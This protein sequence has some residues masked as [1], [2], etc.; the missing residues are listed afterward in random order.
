[1]GRKVKRKLVKG[2]DA[3]AMGAV[4]AGCRNYFGYPITPQN[5]IPEY[6]AAHLPRAGGQY[7]QAESEV[8]AINML[9]GAAATGVRSMT[10]SSSPG[11]SLMQ[12]GI[13]YMAASELPG[14]IVNMV[15]SGPGLGGIAASQADYFQATKGGGHGDYRLIVLAPST[16]QELYDMTIMAFDLAD[17]YRNPVM[18]LGDAILGQMKE[19][20]LE[21][22]EDVVPLSKDDWAL[23][24]AQGR[25]ARHIKSLYLDDD[26]L[27]AHNYK[28]HAKYEEIARNE[29]RF[30]AVCVDDADLVVVA[31]GSAARISRTAV[32]TAREE[33]HRVGLYQPISL[34]PY[35]DEA[36][37]YLSHHVKR[38][39]TVELSMGQMVEDVRLS[40]EGDATVHLFG[41]PHLMTPEEIL[42]QIERIVE[43]PIP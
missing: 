41:K 25:P 9:L 8:A 5:E 15:R 17:K 38:F 39:L 22:A 19:P 34:F 31:Y 23:T 37:R 13:S 28:L 12:E 2:N 36:L 16:V 20:L 43:V 29:I 35:P 6:M 7:V 10:S 21:R 40:V 33:G 32:Q 14:V 18:I 3:I 24:G 42:Q 11:I 27:I 30:E 4:K 26:L 1:M